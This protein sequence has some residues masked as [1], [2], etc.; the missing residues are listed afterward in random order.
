MIQQHQ[1]Y[2][3]VSQ[4]V[5][6][7]GGMGHVIP[8]S[9][10][11]GYVNERFMIGAFPLLDVGMQTSKVGF[12]FVGDANVPVNTWASYLGGNVGDEPA[13]CMRF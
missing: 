3:D 1:A 4:I 8:W 12:V 5:T 7:R 6:D 11:R 10:N 13:C 2:L 9:D